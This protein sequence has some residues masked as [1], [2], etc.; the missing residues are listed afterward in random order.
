MAWDA[1]PSNSYAWVENRSGRVAGSNVSSKTKPSW[2]RAYAICFALCVVLALFSASQLYLESH[3]YPPAPSQV[4]LPGYLRLLAV[5]SEA[6]FC[7]FLLIPPVLWAVERW[8]L[9]PRRLLVRV[10][11]YIAMAIA[12]STLAETLRWVLFPIYAG[13][14]RRSPPRT[15]GLLWE[16]IRFNV[17]PNTCLT[18]VPLIAIAHALHFKA[19]HRKQELEYVELQRSLAERR[20]HALKMN[21]QPHFLF[22]TLQS[23]GT[24]VRRDYKRA[25]LML[26]QLRQLLQTSL[27]YEERSVL[28][29][30]EELSFVNSYIEIEKVRLLDRLHVDLRCSHVALECLVPHMLLQPLVENAVKHG[31]ERARE[32]GWITLEAAVAGERLHLKVRNSLKVGAEASRGGGVGLRNS[33][34]RLHSLYGSEAFLE[35]HF[36]KPDE[37]EVLVIIPAVLSRN[38]EHQFA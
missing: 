3:Q 23:I 22:N 27:E 12:F 5:S 10:L 24:L 18:F 28:P 34:Q 16:L 19:E 25:S 11:L 38:E 1:R 15:L 17:I 9:V 31:I 2:A 37:A 13:G 4:P 20:L 26:Q 35:L 6:F 33:R 29:L 21:L 14:I 7:Y 36:P 30:R 32:G 8:P